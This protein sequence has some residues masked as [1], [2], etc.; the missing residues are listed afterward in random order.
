MYKR[1]YTLHSTC[2]SGLDTA[3]WPQKLWVS[4]AWWRVLLSKPDSEHPQV[5]PCKQTPVMNRETETDARQNLNAHI[6]HGPENALCLCLQVMWWRRLYELEATGAMGHSNGLVITTSVLLLVLFTNYINTFYR[7]S[8]VEDG[9]SGAFFLFKKLTRVKTNCCKYIYPGIKPEHKTQICPFL[10]LWWHLKWKLV[11]LT[12]KTINHN[13]IQWLIHL[14][15]L[16]LGKLCNSVWNNM[17]I[18]AT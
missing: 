7:Q 16:N 12:L 3:P 17:C 1:T 15:I 11:T 2:S 9:V 6:T 18:N 10:R 5:W 14:E 4:A 13:I 8:Q